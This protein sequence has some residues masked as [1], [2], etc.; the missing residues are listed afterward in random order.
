MDSSA[1]KTFED[2]FSKLIAC[3]KQKNLV[4]EVSSH[5]G[6]DS[7]LKNMFEYIWDLDV[8]KEHLDTHI[9]FGFKSEEL[10]NKKRDEGNKFYQKK[11]LDKALKCYNQSILLSPHPNPKINSMVEGEVNLY[12]NEMKKILLNYNLDDSEFKALSLGL[13]NRSAVLYELGQY[14]LCIQDCDHSII[15][16]YPKLLTSKLLERKA[17]CLMSQDK[18]SEAKLVLEKCISDLDNLGLEEE[19]I[20]ITKSGIE[21]L[22]KQ[23]SVSGDKIDEQKKS[24]VLENSS[25]SKNPINYLF[26][27]GKPDPP[28]LV[29]SNPAIPCLSSAVRV[30]YA[31]DRGRFLVA[32]RDIIPGM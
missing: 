29:E 24:E 6:T 17:K 19:K 5:F 20:R 30:E 18:N 31:P 25:D 27:F 12:T 8:A 11:Q 3:L 1:H 26:K 4:N 28:V 32:N 16:G 2:K 10:A 9:N 13:A 23:C 22:I 14:D 7:S 21:K 15:C